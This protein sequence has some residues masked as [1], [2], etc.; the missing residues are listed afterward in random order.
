[1]ETML[2]CRNNVGRWSKMDFGPVH[3]IGTCEFEPKFLI[4]SPISLQQSHPSHIGPV[5]VTLTGENCESGVLI[6]ETLA[7]IFK[8]RPSDRV[9]RAE[10]F[11]AGASKSD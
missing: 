11:M 9:P 6:P 4:K 5:E 10:A 2:D 8:D 1:M 7:S 3:R